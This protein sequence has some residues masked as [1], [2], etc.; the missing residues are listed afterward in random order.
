MIGKIQGKASLMTDIGILS[1]PGALSDGNDITI[2]CTS[3]LYTAWKW[4]LSASEI[5]NFGVQKALA[6]AGCAGLSK[7]VNLERPLHQ[8]K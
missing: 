6:G 4:N 1:H 7:T 2:F 5:Y 8:Q 3:L